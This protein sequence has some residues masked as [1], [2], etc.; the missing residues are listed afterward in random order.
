[1]WF[2]R[3]PWNIKTLSEGW[4][5]PGIREQ[6]FNWKSGFGTGSQSAKFY[7]TSIPADTSNIYCPPPIQAKNTCWGAGLPTRTLDW[8]LRLP[9]TPR[10]GAW[11][12]KKVLKFWNDYRIA[13]SYKHYLHIKQKTKKVWASNIKVFLWY[14]DNPHNNSSPYIFI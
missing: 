1:M 5:V 12:A 8:L 6:I 14:P 7:F 9:S 11:L 4:S 13:V 10:A 3:A 2:G